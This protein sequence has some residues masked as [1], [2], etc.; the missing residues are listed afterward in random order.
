MRRSLRKSGPSSWRGRISSSSGINDDL[1]FYSRRIGHAPA[2]DPPTGGFKKVPTSTRIL[3]AV[4]LTGKTPEGLSVGV[5]QS[6]T[7][8]EMAA[9]PRTACERRQTVEPMTNYTVARVQQDIDKGNTI[10]G[11]IVTATRRNLKDDALDFLSRNAYTGGLDLLRYWHDRTYYLDLRAIG[12]RVDGSPTAMRTL[13]E[14]PVHNYQRPDATHLGVDAQARHLDG[15]GGLLKL[16]KGSNGNWRYYGSLDWRSPGLELNDLG[17]LMTADLIQQSARLQYV[18]T[19]PGRLVRRYDLRLDEAGKYD[20]GGEKLQREVELHGN[21]TFNSNWSLW[22]ELN[23]KSELLDTRVLRGGPA[24]LTP[25]S[26]SLWI[27]AQTDSSR[28]QQFR[29]DFGQAASFDGHSRYAEIAPALFRPPAQHRQSRGQILLCTECRGLPV[30]RH[31][32][33]RR[34]RPLRHGTNEPADPR[35]HPAPGRQSHA[36]SSRCPIT[37][38]PLFPPAGSPASNS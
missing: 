6:L 31:R 16:G 21:L 30:C 26:A 5:L 35:H 38:A 4:K 23:C 11:G 2:F 33:G 8:R 13:M 17:Y 25:G 27:G 1:L 36:R 34:R 32:H 7:D 20:F 24:L 15:T 10:V 9:S 22:G 3:G 14:N 18:N 12:S 19:R 28:K 29:L 37:A